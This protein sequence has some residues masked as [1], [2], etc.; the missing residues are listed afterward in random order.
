MIK[1]DGQFVVSAACNNGT[2]ALIT[3]DGELLMFGKDTSHADPSTGKQFSLVLMLILINV[4]LIDF[5]TCW[6]AKR[7][8]YSSSCFRKGTCS[9]FD[10]QGASV[11]FW[12]K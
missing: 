2:T 3:R 11:H 9:S 12:N 8:I 10:K 7:R 4:Y 1:V 5:R 6:K